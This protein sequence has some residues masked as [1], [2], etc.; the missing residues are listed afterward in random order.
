[1]TNNRMTDFCLYVIQ[2]AMGVIQWRH[3]RLIEVR[4]WRQHR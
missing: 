2:T 1:M 3:T 4:Q